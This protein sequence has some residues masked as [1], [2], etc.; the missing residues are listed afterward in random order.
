M[1]SIAFGARH[2]SRSARHRARPDAGV[3]DDALSWIAYRVSRAPKRASI[4]PSRAANCASRAPKRAS[5][6]LSR[7]S[8]PVKRFWKSRNSA[9]IVRSRMPTQSRVTGFADD[10]QDCCHIVHNDKRLI[11]YNL[12]HAT[13]RRVNESAQ[14]RL[15][16]SGLVGLLTCIN[17]ISIDELNKWIV[18]K[19]TETIFKTGFRTFTRQGSCLECRPRP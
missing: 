15:T 19:L 12:W 9:P 13:I 17:P 3:R 18:L 8:I 10:R 2:R 7:T 11:V 5:S 1:Q 14:R 6:A 16:V 4:A